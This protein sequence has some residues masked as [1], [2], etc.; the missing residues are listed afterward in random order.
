MQPITNSANRA[1]IFDFGGV[2]FKTRDY[3][4]RHAWDDRLGLAHGSV[5]QVVHG[6]ASWRAAQHGEIPLAD[7]WRDV[8]AQLGLDLPTVAELAID[9]YRGDQLDWQVTDVIEQLLNAGVRVAL[10]SNDV[11]DLLRPRLMRLGIFN[12][13]DPLI[14][15][16]EVGVMKPDAAAYHVT[17]TW[18][19]RLPD[20]VIFIDD[21]PQNIAGA[22]ALGIH[23][24]LHHDGQDL[25]NELLP[26]LG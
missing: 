1:V 15:S 3:R 8:A 21:M 10:L 19:E 20:E 18:L 12:W 22:N 25:W 4:P 9:F 17:L 6:S 26:Y 5:E 14:I 24:L 16:S 13:F 2:I 23:T 7:Y 11:A